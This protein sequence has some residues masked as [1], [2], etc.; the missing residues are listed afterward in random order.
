MP[1]KHGRVDYWNCPWCEEEKVQQER[2]YRLT[3]EE[4]ARELDYQ[5]LAELRKI[6][7]LLEGKTNDTVK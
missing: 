5:K 7:E 6:R 2:I 3:Q 4:K 1:C